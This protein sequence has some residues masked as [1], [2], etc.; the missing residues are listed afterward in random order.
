MKEYSICRAAG[1][2]EQKREAKKGPGGICAAKRM[3]K[4]WL[5]RGGPKPDEVFG[6]ANNMELDKRV[7]KEKKRE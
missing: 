7:K 4:R 1:G 3:G 6:K 2:L 5:G